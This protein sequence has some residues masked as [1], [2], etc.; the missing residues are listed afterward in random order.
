MKM[1]KTSPPK[2]R[3]SPIKKK[4]LSPKRCKEINSPD[5]VTPHNNIEEPVLSVSSVQELPF[6]SNQVFSK[7]SSYTPLSHYAS[8]EKSESLTSLKAPSEHSN[9]EI[10]SPSKQQ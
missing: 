10:L 3:E 2:Q 7:C 9:D 4:S 1:V 5:Q 8:F 6:I